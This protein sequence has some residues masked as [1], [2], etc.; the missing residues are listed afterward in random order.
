[1]PSSKLASVAGLGEKEAVPDARPQL[2]AVGEL[3]LQPIASYRWRCAR[4]VVQGLGRTAEDH[5]GTLRTAQWPVLLNRSSTG[6]GHLSCSERDTALRPGAGSGYGPAPSARVPLL[7]V[8][9]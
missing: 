3:L 7:M 4:S 1:M 8:E 5:M 2:L 9:Q 6:H